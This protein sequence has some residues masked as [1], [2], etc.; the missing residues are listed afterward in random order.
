MSVSISDPELFD[1]IVHH[2]F[3]PPQLPQAEDKADIDC[4][5][6]SLTSKALQEFQRELDRAEKKDP[7][8]TNDIKH[9][10]PIIQQVVVAMSNASRCHSVVDGIL[11]ETEV[12]SCLE[13]LLPG[14]SLPLRIQ[15]QN[16][17][18]LITKS[19]HEPGCTSPAAAGAQR[20]R[21]RR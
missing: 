13:S 8:K 5:L 18:L 20:Q 15:A 3:L 14:Q 16:A 6:L 9:A 1:R 10:R 19:V 4:E 2:V 7:L 21:E 11:S 17:G 12:L